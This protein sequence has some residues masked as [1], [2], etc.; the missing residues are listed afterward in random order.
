[1]TQ[2]PHTLTREEL[3]DLIWAEPVARVAKRYGL[4]GAGLRKLCLRQGIPV[5]PRGHW[6]KVAAGQQT[7][8][9]PMQPT[10]KPRA[11]W[12]ANSAALQRR[13]PATKPAHAESP[14]VVERAAYEAEPRH[15]IRINPRKTSSSVWALALREAATK[16]YRDPR[17]LLKMRLEQHAI[18]ATIAQASVARLAHILAALEHACSAR[19]LLQASRRAGQPTRLIVE[20]VPLHLHVSERTTRQELPPDSSQASTSEWLGDRRVYRYEP[21]GALTLAITTTEEGY[22]TYLPASQLI[23]DTPTR[24]L[25]ERLN[26]AI[27]AMVTLATKERRLKTQRAEEAERRRAAEEAARAAALAQQQRQLDTQALENLAVRRE[28]AQRL[29]A[30]I[31]AVAVSGRVPESLGAPNELSA[32]RAWAQAIA[33]ERDPLSS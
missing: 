13:T 22:W 9:P 2:E 1:M 25:E 18:S 20:G 10:T 29:R 28:R 30:L 32:W 3:Y 23:R 26:D 16:A 4:S 33:D 15:R 21:T 7:T 31:D 17:G 8:R 14:E 5:P 12:R 19:N 27:V 6:A 11:A 24:R